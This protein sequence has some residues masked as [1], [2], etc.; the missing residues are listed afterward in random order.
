MNVLTL[1]VPESMHAA[2]TATSRAR[3]VSKSALVRQAIEQF[4]S[5]PANQAGAASGWVEQWRSSM[6]APSPR[7][8]NKAANQDLRPAHLLAKHLR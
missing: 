4:L 2:L 1:K 7:S 3:G 6:S 8:N 5:Q